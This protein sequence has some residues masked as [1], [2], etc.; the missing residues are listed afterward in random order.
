VGNLTVNVFDNATKR[1]IWRGSAE[2]TLSS[3]PSKNDK[4]LE[5]AVE[6]MFEHFP[7]GSRG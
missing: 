2:K 5:H 3:K 7:A 4:K 6:E 1:M